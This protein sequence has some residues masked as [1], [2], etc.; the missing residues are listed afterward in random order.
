M[1][2]VGGIELHG[3]AST[4]AVV[5]NGKQQIVWYFAG[6]APD[7]GA[8]E[9]YGGRRIIVD[10]EDWGARD[11]CCSVRTDDFLCVMWRV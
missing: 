5:A 1:N 7:L 2:S 3:V 6:D 4:Q 8:N 9:L 10:G 11:V